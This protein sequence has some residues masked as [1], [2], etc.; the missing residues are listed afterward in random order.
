MLRTAGIT[1]G[2]LDHVVG[3]NLRTSGTSSTQDRSHE[4]Q[5]PGRGNGWHNM[6]LSAD[7][8]TVFM[9]PMEGHDGG[10]RAV[11]DEDQR[12]SHFRIMYAPS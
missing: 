11:D 9:A 4:G 12:P 10:R 3:S 2:R 5:D 6:G 1:D 7:G 8:K